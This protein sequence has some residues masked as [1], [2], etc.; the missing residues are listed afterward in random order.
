MI[1][2]NVAQSWQQ[3]TELTGAKSIR[4]TQVHLLDSGI[5]ISGDF[6]LPPLAG[7][8]ADDQIFLAAFV[9]SHGSIKQ[10]EKLFGVSYPTIKN[11]LN[12]LGEKLGFVDI[13]APDERLVIL[14]QLDR[15]ELTVE[16]AIKRLD[17]GES[18]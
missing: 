15:G 16:E 12:K 6:E 13:Q 17:T 7:L 9:K 3:L 18:S 5:T 4:V 11:R 8:P 14:D 10:M 1:G 2:G